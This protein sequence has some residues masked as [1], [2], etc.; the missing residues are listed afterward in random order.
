L[1]DG[2]LAPGSSFQAS[3]HPF[4]EFS[5]RSG[6]DEILRLRYIFDSEVEKLGGIAYQGECSGH[7]WTLQFYRTPYLQRE[8]YRVLCDGNLIVTTD[9]FRVL[10][11]DKITYS[12]GTIWHC[13]IG[14]LGLEVEDSGGT[15]MLHSSLSPGLVLG[16]S[17]LHIDHEIGLDHGL[18]L[19][20]ILTHS[21]THNSH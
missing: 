21:T 5:L 11:S 6:N 20:I 18:P 7:Y 2:V 19:L 10:R 9:V 3:A 14:I 12:D 4:A 1:F 17:S 8:S 13:H 16:G 15:R